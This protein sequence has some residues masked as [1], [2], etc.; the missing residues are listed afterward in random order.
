MTSAEIFNLTDYQS[1]P[2]IKGAT[3]WEIW[4]FRLFAGIC[5]LATRLGMPGFVKN[6]DL[7]DEVTGQIISIRVESLFTMLS[8][9]GRDYYFRRLTGK[10]D[11]TGMGCCTTSQSA[12]C[13]PGQTRRSTPSLADPCH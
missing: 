5:V 13:R 12:C 2:S 4:R 8:V 1:H 9:N 3:W 6:L 7:V 11:G 10:L